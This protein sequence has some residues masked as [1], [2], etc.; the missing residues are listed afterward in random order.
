MGEFAMAAVQGRLTSWNG[1]PL[2]PTFVDKKVVA[3]ILAI[4]L[5]Q[6]GVHKFILGYTNA[7]IV[8]VAVTVVS[9]ILTFVLIGI[10]GILAM[11]GI[12]IAEGIIYLTRSDDEFVVRY[13]VNKKS[14]F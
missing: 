13:G 11:S 14:W 8:M 10:F 2:P 6:F 3:G 12:G 4:L 5:G 1:Q 9:Y 7:G